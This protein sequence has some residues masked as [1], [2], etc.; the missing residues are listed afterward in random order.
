MTHPPETW[1]RKSVILSLL[2]R[3][4]ATSV[5]VG[6]VLV[7][8]VQTASAS[9]VGTG[10]PRAPSGV[11]PKSTSAPS[12]RAG[13]S[14]AYD[15]ATGST[16][17]FG[18]SADN[19]TW[20]W[21]GSTWTQQFPTTSPPARTDASMAYDASI[22]NIVLFGGQSNGT[23]GPPL[24]DDTW[25]WSGTDWVQQFPIASPP[26]RSGASMAY[27][28]T[29]GALVLFGGI[30]ATPLYRYFTDNDT[31]T[32]SGTTW[33]EA[34]PV[35]SP[36]ARVWASMAYDA[37]TGTVVLFGGFETTPS[38]DTW[39]W[40][41]TTWAEQTPASSPPARFDASMA[42]DGANGTVVLFGGLGPT[43]PVIPGHNGLDDT[44]TWDG[45]NW[46]QQFPATSPSTA[47]GASMDFDASSGTVVLF[48]GSQ[49][50]QGPSLNGT[51]T[52]DGSTWASHPAPSGYLLAA[53]DG[54]VFAFGTAVFQGSA[55]GIHLNAPI[56]GTAST[57]DGGG[58]WLV[59]SDGGVF[60]FGDAGFFGSMGGRHLNAPVVGMAAAP[61]GGGYWLVASDGGVFAFGDAQYQGSAG[62][63]H[64]KA[65]IVGMTSSFDGYWLV[66][67][68]GGIFNY[69]DSPFY[70][71]AGSMKLNRPI[72]GMAATSDDA[73]YSLVASDGGIFTF[74]DAV[75]SGS[76]GG[77]HLNAPVVGM[78][79]TG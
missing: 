27:D 75:F 33:I 10:I 55:G 7:L 76:T 69:G 34:E 13:A 1:R 44:W 5:I 30:S 72:V 63:T 78:V 79:A 66:A 36:P 23:S 60:S 57:P 8:G 19:D 2:S 67:S 32:W 56:V 65:P 38:S 73:G 77:Q 71:S 25:V 50:Q 51:W 17:L 28:A 41:G 22:G 64:L 11:V 42:Y 3:G 47:S 74:G 9:P 18:G 43:P 48:G 54:G 58:Y 16:V 31:W 62:G 61:Y 6:T 26:A 37:T 39:I 40:N 14:M 68:D 46:T 15:P 20:T 53:A 59:G 52:W 4:V 70:G 45:T 21:N 24:L 49:Q 35:T 29:T 12:P